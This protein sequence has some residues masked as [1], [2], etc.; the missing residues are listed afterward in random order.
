MDDI[1]VADPSISR[2]TTAAAVSSQLLSSPRMVN[3]RVMALP[4]HP[5]GPGA[6]TIGNGKQSREGMMVALLLTRPSEAAARFLAVLP[7]DL[8]EQLA[9]VV[10]PL[11]KI[12]PLA[13]PEDLADYAGAVFSSAAGVVP[14]PVSGLPAYCVGERTAEAAAGA[15]WQS[16]VCGDNADAL[17]AVLP[18]MNVAG[19]LLHMHG[20][21]TRG[22][23]A[24]RLSAAGLRCDARVVYE[25]EQMEF[26]G[27]AQQLFA[28]QA[29]VVA[30]VFSPR[31]ARLFAEKCSDARG[32]HF[33]AFSEA[34]AEPL[35]IL[36][37]KSL[38]ICKAPNSGEMAA[39]LQEVAGEVLRVE[40]GRSAQ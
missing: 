40:G 3:V 21:H 34:V 27:E 29:Q 37:Y 26:T 4:L 35:K 22:R 12:R 38:R 13:P 20:R 2:R 16:H 19:P 14:P 36:N 25:Q 7:R 6:T 33:L 32:I 10:S 8:V 5:A 17:V 9:I 23:V 28:D 1:T 24:E 31:T 30:P 11:L 15:G 18:Q 39:L